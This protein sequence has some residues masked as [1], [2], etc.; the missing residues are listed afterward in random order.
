MGQLADAR[1]QRICWVEVNAVVQHRYSVFGGG[2]SDDQ[3]WNGSPMLAV[4]AEQT[5]ARTRTSWLAPGADA[6]YSARGVR[7][8]EQ[9]WDDLSVLPW[10]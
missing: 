10:L 5:L 2:C 8:Y 1:M 4:A 3:I 9:R 7:D 6:L